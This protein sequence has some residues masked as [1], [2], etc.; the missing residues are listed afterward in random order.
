MTFLTDLLD[1]LYAGLVGIYVC[2]RTT[3]EITATA[4]NDASRN[5]EHSGNRKDES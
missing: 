4:P 2:D 1:G 5:Q 3:T